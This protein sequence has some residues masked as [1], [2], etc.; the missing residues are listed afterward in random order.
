MALPRLNNKNNELRATVRKLA[1]LS[2]ELKAHAKLQNATYRL[3]I[4]MVEED[5]KPKHQYW[6]ERAAGEILNDYDP[7][8]P[9]KLPDPNKELTDEEKK[10][11]PP[12]FAP[13]TRLMKKPETLPDGLLFE[14]VEL[15]SIEGPVSSG[16]V[17]IHYLPSGFAD[18]AA[19][20]LKQ[21][22]KLKWTLAIDPITG[23]V[24]IIDEFRSLKDL[25]AK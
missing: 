8:D 16:L 20:H 3:V 22:D 5:R 11:P 1:V 19:I 15:G 21:G 6:V 4:N 18:E 24:D 10:E 7:K 2:R 25:R 13:D 14:S 12:P 23:R 9:P 17:Y